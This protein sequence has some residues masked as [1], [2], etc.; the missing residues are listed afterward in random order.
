[1]P[2]DRAYFVRVPRVAWTRWR[3]PLFD[4]VVGEGL[5]RAWPQM[6]LPGSRLGHTLGSAALAAGE[7]MC[8]CGP[9]RRRRRRRCQSID[10]SIAI[11]GLG[12]L[13][14]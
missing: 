3:Q 6:L 5:A 7:L 10:R 2:E 14:L 9:H 12:T 13:W 4:G 11:D 8:P 1:M